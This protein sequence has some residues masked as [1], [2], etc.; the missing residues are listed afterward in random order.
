MAFEFIKRQID[1][2]IKAQKDHFGVKNLL[3]DRLQ[4]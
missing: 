1:A 2:G 3:T 4:S